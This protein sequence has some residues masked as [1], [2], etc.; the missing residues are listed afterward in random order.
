MHNIV[1]QYPK[2]QCNINLLTLF[3]FHS[4]CF[5]FLLHYTQIPLFFFLKLFDNKTYYS[6]IEKWSDTSITCVLPKIIG[7]KKLIVIT[8]G[9]SKKDNVKG[10]RT[11]GRELYGSSGDYIDAAPPSITAIGVGILMTTPKTEGGEVLKING[12]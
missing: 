2:Q 5:I 1:K 8:N 3:P 9:K 12:K 10:V 6:T 4:L 7:T 11:L